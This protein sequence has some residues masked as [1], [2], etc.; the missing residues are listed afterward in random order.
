MAQVSKF[1]FVDNDA[2]K[3][4]RKL[5]RSH[6]MK[7]KNASKAKPRCDQKFVNKTN[8]SSNRIPGDALTSIDYASKLPLLE[9]PLGDELSFI[10]FPCKAD[11]STRRLIHQFMVVQLQ[12]LYP[13]EFCF[14]MD[15]MR[16]TWFE[17]IQ[18]S[19]T[20]YH[21]SLVM[22]TICIDGLLG[23]PLRSP[24]ALRHLADTY[25]CINQDLRGQGTPSD[26]TFA[27]VVSLA[28]H[29]NLTNQF[30][31]S[32]VH[33]KALQLMLEMRGGIKAFSS[34]WVIWHK[35][36]RADIDR[37]LHEGC[38]SMYYRDTLPK[39]TLRSSS[40]KKELMSPDSASKTLLPLTDPGLDC[41]ATDTNQ[42]CHLLN[43]NPAR[44]SLDPADFQ[45][46]LI[47]FAYRLLQYC[48]LA[49]EPPEDKLDSAI[50]TTL[51]GF[52]TTLLFEQGRMHVCAYDLLASRLRHA[53]S[54]LMVSITLKQ[55]PVLLW[56]LFSGGISLCGPEDESWLCPYITSCLS[57]LEI[58]TWD[59]AHKV[60]SR[61]PWVRV[62]H[63]KPGFKLWQTAKAHDDQST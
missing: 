63:D 36:C 15:H 43:Q 51:L 45:N 5:I 12:V 40:V 56:V 49:G 27:V 7:G 38:D 8:E 20:F 22:A 54:E 57:S 16:S 14:Q 39:Q 26:A 55:Q 9:R 60:I 47:T 4:N 1:Q 29:E 6:V 33:L 31:V 53:I 50:F 41:I 23:K 10:T 2:L 58:D 48:P 30:G 42:F 3:S 44:F 11:L 19:E 18:R 62:V 46:A 37:A 17:Y 32:K 35:I 24:Q 28:V 21:C 34:N 61:L 52:L 13:K 59:A 25:K